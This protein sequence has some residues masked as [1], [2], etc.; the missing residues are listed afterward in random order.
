MSKTECLAIDKA[1]MDNWMTPIIQYLEDGTCK[2]K[3]EKRM[4]QQCARY[5]MINDDLYRKRI[6]GPSTEVHHQQTGRVYPD[7]DPQGGLWKSLRG[8]DDGR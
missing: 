8:E 7:R 4:K 3:L 1:E 2:P 6:L 5:T